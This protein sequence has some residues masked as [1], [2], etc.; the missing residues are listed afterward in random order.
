MAS[1]QVLNAQSLV[2]AQQIMSAEGWQLLGTMLNLSGDQ[3]AQYA[4]D[5]AKYAN[6]NP[7]QKKVSKSFSGTMCGYKVENGEIG[8]EV[9]AGGP[10]LFVKGKLTISGLSSTPVDFL[11]TFSSGGAVISGQITKSLTV[12]VIK[13]QLTNPL[14]V[15]SVSTDGV[16]TPGVGGD[17][18]LASSLESSFLMLIIS[19][20][21]NSTGL[22]ESSVFIASVSELTVTTIVEAI[23]HTSVPAA[24]AS[25]LSIV[26]ITHFKDEEFSIDFEVWRPTSTRKSSPR[27]R[28]RSETSVASRTCPPLWTRR[29]SSC[30]RRA[31]NG[32][33]PTSK[34]TSTAIISW[35]KATAAFK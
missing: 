28:R 7:N 31:R 4:D 10:S 19:S 17:L 6:A 16:A 20:S 24:I 1:Q 29:C 27:Y 35:R 9:D 32:R 14:L 23:A 11:T 12:P 22:D 5:L 25:L 13:L 33:S 2:S 21:D 30:A 34:T 15:I 26:K 18:D 8:I 3:L